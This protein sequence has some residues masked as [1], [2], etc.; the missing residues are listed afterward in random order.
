[1]EICVL[2]FVSQGLRP[3]HH[4]IDHFIDRC[5]VG[6]LGLLTNAIDYTCACESLESPKE[7]THPIPSV[8]Y[9]PTDRT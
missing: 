3:L 9:G 7:P 6:I 5:V 2:V 4:E 8:V 1:M